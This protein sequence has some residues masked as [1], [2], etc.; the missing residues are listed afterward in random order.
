MSK[1]A[2]ITGGT[3]GIGRQ[4]AVT[5]AKAGMD[6]ENISQIKDKIFEE[7]LEKARTIDE[8]LNDSSDEIIDVDTKTLE[9]MDKTINAVESL[10]NIENNNESVA[11]HEE[12]TL[13]S[14]LFDLIDS[15]YENREDGE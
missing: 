1:V 13:E 12:D 8:L 2:F 7:K 10:E 3:R 4:I 9:E 6:F 14:D 11:N 5:L 15:M